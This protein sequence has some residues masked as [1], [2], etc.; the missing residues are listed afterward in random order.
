MQA[1]TQV[2]MNRMG[3]EGYPGTACGVIYQKSQFSWTT[4]R[5]KPYLDVESSAWKQ[6]V[7]V[8]TQMYVDG[9]TV[10]GLESALFYHAVYVSPRWKGVIELKKVGAHVF[11]GKK[12][13]PS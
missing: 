5:S 9:H 2:V 12:Y 10:R 1:V 4:Q 11:Y 3:A 13:L 6:A 8:A 7:N